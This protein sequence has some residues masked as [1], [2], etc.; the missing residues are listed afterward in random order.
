MDN[1][2]WQNE[3]FILYLSGTDLTNVHLISTSKD[4]QSQYD[5]DEVLSLDD[6]IKKVDEMLNYFYN[7]WKVIESSGDK[8]LYTMYFNINLVMINIPISYFI[9]IKNTLDSLKSVIT[10]N[11]KESYFKIE[12]KLARHFLDF[13]LIFYTPIKPIHLI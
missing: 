3:Y 11:I 10:S 4:I 6:K 12:N 13:V 9:K 2:I 1:L 7:F 8:K 5:S